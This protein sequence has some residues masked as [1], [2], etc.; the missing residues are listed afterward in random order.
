ML[1]DCRVRLMPSF[2][3]CSWNTIRS[4]SSFE[5]PNA[6]AIASKKRSKL[7]ESIDAVLFI[8]LICRLSPPLIDTV[9]LGQQYGG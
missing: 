7:C 5:V 6:R 1:P 2:L 4:N 9:G 3:I 8:S